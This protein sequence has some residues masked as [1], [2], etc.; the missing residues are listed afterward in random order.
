MQSYQKSND[1]LRKVI[2]ALHMGYAYCLKLNSK[3]KQ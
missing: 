3:C 1:E 2:S